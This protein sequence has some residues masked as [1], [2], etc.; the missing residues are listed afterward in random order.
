MAFMRAVN[1]TG[2]DRN[3]GRC[4]Q[5]GRRRDE[6]AAQ[7]DFKIN[8]CCSGLRL[9]G[10]HLFNFSIIY[11]YVKYIVCLNQTLHDKMCLYML[12]WRVESVNNFSRCVS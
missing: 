11:I 9:R 10:R 4:S 2:G 7:R 6:A 12:R 1:G 8:S 5:R 3:L